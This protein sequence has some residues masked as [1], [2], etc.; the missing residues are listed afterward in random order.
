[1]KPKVK[2]LVVSEEMIKE[3]E[4]SCTDKK[5]GEYN[6]GSWGNIAVYSSSHLKGNQF[7]ELFEE[8]FPPKDRYKKI[9]LDSIRNQKTNHG[10]E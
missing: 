5:V 4:G 1:M 8:N 2:G 6:I 9:G 3:L 10:K 7:I